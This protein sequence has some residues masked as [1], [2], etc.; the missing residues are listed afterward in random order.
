[1]TNTEL[2]IELAKYS[3]PSIVFFGSAYYFTN[4]WF[5]IQN[6]KIKVSAISDHTKEKQEKIQKPID[7][8]KTYFPLQIDAVQRLV[9]FLERISPTNMVMRLHNPGLSAKDFQ[10]KLLESIRSE[11]EHNLAQQVFVSSETW[12]VVKDSKEE[13][14]KIVNM[15]ATH[16][17]ADAFSGELGK[18]IFEISA[19]L[20]KQPTEVPIEMLK[21]ELRNSI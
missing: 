10:Q 8:Q 16:L 1:M 20:K 13:V 18:A 17:S 21:S 19:Q 15:A 7:N 6:N 14:V 12:E 9:L 11:F 4:K 5:E 2:I 3:I